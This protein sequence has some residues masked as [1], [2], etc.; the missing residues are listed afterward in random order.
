[1]RIKAGILCLTAAAALVFSLPLSAGAADHTV[2]EIQGLADGIVSYKVSSSGSGSVQDWINGALAQGAGSSSEW[3]VI[4]L[5]QSGS[6]DFSQYRSALETYLEN[7]SV[8]SA[9][10]RQKYALALIA[11]GSS[12][13]Y[14]TRT[15]GDSIGQLGIMSWDYGLHLLNNGVS[16]PY[17]AE[18]AVNGIL[19]MQLGDGGWAVIGDYGDVDVTAMTINAL[20]PHY[21]YN[22]AIQQ[23]V[24]VGLDF[25]SGR[26][27]DSGGFKT[28][29]AEN[30]ESSAQV[31]TA[32]S[33]LGIDCQT[34]S[35]FI[36]EGNSPI[37]G[38]LKYR[39]GDGSFAH[40]EGGGM[41]D[42]ATVQAYYSFI[43]YLRMTQGRT[44]LLILD[45]Q[46]EPELPVQTEPVSPPEIQE[47]AAAETPA[48]SAA[49]QV[50]TPEVSGTAAAASGAAEV[51]YTTENTVT[52]TTAGTS[53]TL[54]ASAAQTVSFTVTLTSAEQSGTTVTVASQVITSHI[55]N[56][57]GGSYKPWAVAVV[58]AAAAV[59]I[60]I[61]L[62][63]GKRSWKNFAAVGV[64]AAAGV[65]V[66][67]LTDIRSPEDY[68]TSTVT[69]E[70][71]VGT[72]TMTI[73]CDT[74]KDEQDSEYAE[75]IPED[76]VILE[77]TDFEFAEGDSVYT[78]LTDAA[79]TFGLQTDS[80]GGMTGMV[81]VAGINYLY[82][83]QFGDLSGWIYHVNGVAPS[84]GCGEY[85]VS[86]GDNIEWL[87]TREV[88]N[89]LD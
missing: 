58:T 75:Y 20:A 81:Y 7:N 85:I 77:T 61:L 62:A 22:G 38:M 13:D 69:K 88:G 15:A 84:V 78:I 48:A 49:A 6:Y 32:L 9:T 28:M 55:H 52:D 19:S 66:I 17:S 89:D 29:G 36:K 33:A 25:L 34:D 53:G 56:K 41:N 24:N 27:L 50:S 8:Y 68:Y 64:L 72:V 47:T 79:R 26:Q 71:A 10:A 76:G 37:D 42:S 54:T 67:V 14:I 5:S 73:R 39:L 86:D 31:I 12:S 45:R 21:P 80:R 63:L 23:A 35:R 65:A 11:A 57:S 82:E 2:G 16:S 87:Y 46:P 40:A 74:I 51:S 60:L 3:Y 43:A 30:P 70:N 18:D 4:G 83:Y 44:P 59:M 1:M